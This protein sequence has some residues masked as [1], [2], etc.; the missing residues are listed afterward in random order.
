[1]LLYKKCR[2]NDQRRVSDQEY[3]GQLVLLK[4]FSC[5]PCSN[6]GI[7]DVKR[8]ERIPS[9]REALD[10]S[11]GR[12]RKTGQSNNRFHRD[13][14]GGDVENSRNEQIDVAS[15][16]DGT[17]KPFAAPP[18]REA[19]PDA[20]EQICTQI[21]PYPRG[22]ERN[23]I[24]ETRG[25]PRSMGAPSSRKHRADEICAEKAKALK[26]DQFDP[27]FRETPPLNNAGALGTTVPPF[28][29]ATY[30]SVIE[31]VRS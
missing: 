1:M 9:S 30:G 27:S 15:N 7:G 10:K 16:K 28:E 4:T 2:R 12:T 20:I 29:A 17:K 3:R 25:D 8:R 26:G 5:R 23:Q 21:N 6:H 22:P 19:Q 14:W 11:H 31:E 13:K 18:N 24:I